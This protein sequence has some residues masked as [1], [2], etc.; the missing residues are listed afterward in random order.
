MLEAK[1]GRFPNKEN[2]LH[3]YEDIEET[4][5]VLLS[6]GLIVSV[7][8]SDGVLCDCRSGGIKKSALTG[9]IFFDSNYRVN[10]QT[11]NAA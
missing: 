11:Q 9:R 4:R 6:N 3:T 1:S 7:K 5:K 2:V 8:N 10:W